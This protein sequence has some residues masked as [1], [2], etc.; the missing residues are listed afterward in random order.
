MRREGIL[1]PE[2]I[3]VLTEI[4]YTEFLVIADDGLPIPKNIKCI[5]LSL[6]KGCA[7]FCE[8]LV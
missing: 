6:I 2:L 7:I 3:Y 4:G 1:N 8:G 5:D